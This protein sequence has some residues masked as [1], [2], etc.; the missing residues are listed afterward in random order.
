LFFLE[1]YDAQAQDQ[2]RRREAPQREQERQGEV[3]EGRRQAQLHAQERQAQPPPPWLGPPEGHGRR[4]GPQGAVPLRV[5]S[6]GSNFAPLV[7]AIDAAARDRS[8][9]R[10]K[11]GLKWSSFSALRP[12][13]CERQEGA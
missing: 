6:L 8:R 12:P 4:E 11:P 1:K 13:Q 2:A 9:T 10:W 7:G 5:A 3:L